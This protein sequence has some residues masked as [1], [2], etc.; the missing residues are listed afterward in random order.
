[1]DYNQ[2]N[3]WNFPYLFFLSVK[4]SLKIML[5]FSASCELAGKIPCSKSGQWKD[6]KKLHSVGKKT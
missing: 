5:M 6:Q 3:I 1:M 2:T 4:N